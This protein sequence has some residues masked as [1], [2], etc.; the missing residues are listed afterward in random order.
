MKRTV[1]LSPSSQF[2][3]DSENYLYVDGVKVARFVPEKECLQFLDK[4]RIRSTQ[5]GSNVV[6]IPISELAKLAEKK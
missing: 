2:R 4:D 5:R 3:V 1:Q 6:E